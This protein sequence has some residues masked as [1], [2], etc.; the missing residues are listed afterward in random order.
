MGRVHWGSVLLGVALGFVVRHLL[1][2]R[3]RATS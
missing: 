1:Q 3:S 2:N